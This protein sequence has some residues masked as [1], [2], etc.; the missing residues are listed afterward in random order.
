MKK[1]LALVLFLTL[2]VPYG[3][4]LNNRAAMKYYSLPNGHCTAYVTGSHE[5]VTAGHCY[6]GEGSPKT[7]GLNGRPYRVLSFKSDSHDHVKLLVDGPRFWWRILPFVR[8]I[9]PQAVYTYGNPPKT[10]TAYREGYFVGKAQ[11]WVVEREEDVYVTL[12]T[13]NLFQL[14][15][16]PGDSGSVIFSYWGYPIGIVSYSAGVIS[17]GEPVGQ[18]K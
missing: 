4:R 13:V 1:L 9:Q 10:Y 5:V 14:F 7:I 15:C 12:P 16:G 11:N 18:F 17:A 3:M 6:L 2:G 8:P